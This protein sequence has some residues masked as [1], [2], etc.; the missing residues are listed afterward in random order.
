VLHL[1]VDESLRVDALEFER[2]LD[3]AARLERQGAPS[4][5]LDTYRQALAL[6]DTDYLPD[7]SGGDWLEWERDRLRGRFVAAAIRAGELSLARGDTGAAQALGQRAL[8][9]DDWSEEA[10]QLLVSALLESGDPAGA[11]RQLRRCLEAL[12]DLGVPPQPRTVDLAR[13]LELRRRRP[14]GPG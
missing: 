3:E 11:R 6:W 1:V 12:E 8:R 2:H 5:A 14:A 9:I 10:H 4:A 7:V 13:R